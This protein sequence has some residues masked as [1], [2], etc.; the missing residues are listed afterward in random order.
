MA[1]NINSKRRL[2]SVVF[3]ILLTNGTIC[4][5]SEYNSS[6]TVLIDLSR[7][8]YNESTRPNISR[9]LKIVSQGISQLTTILD[10]P[11][12]ITFL[13]ITD[14]SLS[15]PVIASF[16]FQPKIFVSGTS[17]TITA[18]KD[19]EKHLDLTSEIITRKP[20]SNFTDISGAI[21]LATRVVS[22][23]SRG[24]RIVIVMSDM[25]EDLK[26]KAKTA[27]IN[28]NG[29]EFLI[30]YR[31][32]PI[33]GSDPNKLNQRLDVWKERLIAGGASKVTFINDATL[34]PSE[35]LQSTRD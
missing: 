19:L 35:I 4:F 17:D 30:L 33:D 9:L 20:A 10:S 13:S 11:V 15:A 18:K 5:A 21:D 31:I 1:W 28:A 7:T 22:A 26:P 6:I 34:S 12:K 27:T 2:M 25:I 16:F 3:A 8:Y 24:K 14:Q 23:Q 29:F 32:L